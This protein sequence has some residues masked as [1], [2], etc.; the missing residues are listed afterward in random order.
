VR[1]ADDLSPR[2]VRF[3]RY[4]PTASAG[5]SGSSIRWRT[6]SAIGG[7]RPAIASGCAGS[8]RAILRQ[9]EIP[10]WKL[11]LIERHMRALVARDI[12]QIR[13]FPGAAAMLSAL[14]SGGM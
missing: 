9:L 13:L 5:F 10:L 11:P 1:Y 4:A 14:K 12:D 6:T 2:P 8:I 7:W 3:R